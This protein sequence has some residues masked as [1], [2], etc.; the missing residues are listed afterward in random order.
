M[1]KSNGTKLSGVT[2]PYSHVG[3]TNNT[4]YYYVITAVNNNG[5]SA[6]SVQVM[7]TTLVV[8]KGVSATPRDGNNLISWLAVSGAA[9]YNVYWSTVAGVNKTNGNK[10]SGATSPL[11]HTGLSNGAAY[12]YV[13]TPQSWRGEGPESAEVNATPVAAAVMVDPLYA[14]QWNL[15][16]TGQQGVIAPS[17]SIGEDIN[18]EP[19]WLTYKGTGVHI[20]VVDDGLEIGHEDLVANIAQTGLSHNYVTGSFDPTNDSTDTASGHG[21]A[22]AGI[23]AARDMNGLGGRGAAPRASLLGYNLLQSFTTSNEADAMTRGSPNVHISNNS[24]G[25]PDNAD[26]HASASTWRAAIEAGLA[27]GRNGRGTIYTWAAGNGGAL[28][29]SNYDGQTNYRGVIAVAAVNDQGKQASYSESGANLWISAPA[30]E[31]CDTHTIST[32]DRSGGVG[33][34]TATTAGASDYANPD[35][36]RCM[37]G[38]SSAAPAAAGAIA[39]LLE[40]N[41]NLG[42]RDVR[43]ILAQSARKNDATDPGWTTG[44]TLPAYHYNH[45]YGFGV[46][47]AQAAITLAKTWNNV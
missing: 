26:L 41:P 31:F 20:A 29:N 4:T 22:V 2:S 1:T 47:D 12:Y 6:E 11:V 34:N 5:E 32:T 33:L 9:S 30:G 44:V 21:T 19:A 40:A 28:D 7:A 46:I 17:G 23:A 15:K 27:T 8:V 38:T 37:N 13:I 42:W 16:N 18:V 10:I 24:W 45:K 3:L 35:Y 36:T 25:A 43:L 39:L 14:D